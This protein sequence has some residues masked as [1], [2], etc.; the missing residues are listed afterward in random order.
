[1]VPC[2][3]AA[4]FSFAVII[5]FFFLFEKGID[6]RQNESLD[7]REVLA[8]LGLES[9]VSLKVIVHPFGSVG[10]VMILTVGRSDEA[11]LSERGIFGQ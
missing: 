9:A 4:A 10:R 3:L 8:G 5:G 7:V 6:R 2:A 11:L 1:V